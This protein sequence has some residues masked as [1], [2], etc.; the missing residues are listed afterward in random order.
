MLLLSTVKTYMFSRLIVRNKDIIFHAK[1][2]MSSLKTPLFRTVSVNP[3]QL[4]SQAPFS[5]AVQDLDPHG[6]FERLSPTN[7][8]DKMTIFITD[9]N[10]KVHETPCKVG[11][12]L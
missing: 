2:S 9:R 4:V 7:P 10:G 11:D 1:R 12:N 5:S 6:G 8:A 3:A